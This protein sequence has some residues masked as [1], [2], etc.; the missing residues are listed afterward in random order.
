MISKEAIDSALAAH[1]QWKKRLNDAI[2]AGKSE[3]NVDTVK[4]DNA[5]QFGQWLNSLPDEIQKT[6]DYQNIKNLHAEFHITASEILGLALG[7]KKD[8]ARNKLEPG[9]GYGRISGKLVLAL[10]NWK[11]KLKKV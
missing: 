7:G 6:Q 4:K 9:G 3:F 8:E 2:T 10:S 11:D 5:C 1:S